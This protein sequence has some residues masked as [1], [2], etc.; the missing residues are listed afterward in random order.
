MHKITNAP[1]SLCRAH[2]GN[3]VLRTGLMYL[4]ERG[5]AGAAIMAEW[6][7]HIGYYDLAQMLIISAMITVFTMAVTYYDSDVPGQNPPT[8]F[9]PRKA[10][11]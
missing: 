8:P 4:Y 2:T 10:N 3:E 5:V 1:S 9:S 11:G 7:Q 6:L